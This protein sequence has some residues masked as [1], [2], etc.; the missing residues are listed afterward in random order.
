MVAR[1]FSM[2]DV[3]KNSQHCSLGIILVLYFLVWKMD[4]ATVAVETVILRLLVV[5]ETLVLNLINTILPQYVLAMAL[6]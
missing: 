2:T 3:T 1:K 5:A 4:R 6:L